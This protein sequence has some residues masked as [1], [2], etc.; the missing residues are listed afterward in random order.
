MKRTFKIL[1][2]TIISIITIYT[3]FIIEESIRT[4]NNMNS[5]PVIILNKKN[6][7]ENITY[8]SLGFKLTNKYGVV[9]DKKT[10]IGQE[11]WLFDSFLI[12]A[13]IS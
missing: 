1:G 8:N 9:E 12:W 7:K 2:I 11:F 13:W 5:K 4:S 10:L 6:K 3:I